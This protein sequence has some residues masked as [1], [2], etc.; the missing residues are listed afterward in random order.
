MGH[1]QQEIS[2]S[3]LLLLGVQITL[4]NFILLA[5]WSRQ[6]P[7]DLVDLVYA[8]IDA[9]AAYYTIKRNIPIA[10]TGS[11]Y[12]TQV[13][14]DTLNTASSLLEDLGSHNSHTQ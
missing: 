14:W 2:P 10:I 6:T 7:F 11:Q 3:L 12:S 8:H 5:S 13:Q 1:L 4:I 9:P